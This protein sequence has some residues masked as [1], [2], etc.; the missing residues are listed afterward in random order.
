M[1]SFINKFLIVFSIL[2]YGLF[3]TVVYAADTAS[4][5]P[6]GKTT[7]LDSNGKPLTGGKVYFK[8]PASDSLKTTWQDGAE[9]V[10]NANPVILDSAGRA[11]I[12][13]FG[14]YRQQV[15]DKNSNLIWDTVTSSAGTGGGGGSTVGD[16]NSVGTVLP[17]SGL[18][19]PTNYVFAYGQEIARVTYPQFFT[20]ITTIQAANCTLGSPTLSGL[21][22]TTQIPI[23]API[24]A[25]CLAAGATV[26]SKTASSVTASVNANVSTNILVTFF[27]WGNGNGTTTFNV[28]DYRGRVLAGRDNMGGTAASRL[29]TTYFANASAIGATGGL[30]SSTTTIAQ[31]NLPSYTLP[32]TLGWAQDSS[33]INNMTTGGQYGAGG[34]ATPYVTGSSLAGAVTI[35]G[36]VTGS[37][38]SGGSGTAITNSIVQPTITIN[39]I[40]KVTPDA[41]A[42][43]ATLATPSPLTKTDDTNVTLTLG[44]TPATS[45]L[46]PV[47]LTLGWNGTLSP[48]RGGTGADLSATGGTSQVVKQTSVGGAFTVGQLANTDISGLGTFATQN[49]ATPPAIGGGT[50]AAGAFTTLSAT[51]NLTTNVTGTQCLHVAGT[52]VISG[53]GADCGNSQWVTSGSDIYYNAGKV[54]IGTATPGYLLDVGSGSG[55]QVMRINGGSSGASAGP[56]LTFGYGGVNLAAI[57]GY[58]AILGGAYNTALVFYTGGQDFIFSGGNVGIGNIS[59][60]AKL[61]I[62]GTM[63]LESFSA[64]SLSVNASHNVSSSSPVVVVCANAAGDAAKI[65]T[66]ITTGLNVR[67]TG[68]C[69]GDA[70]ISMTTP[71]QEV[72]CDSQNANP[73]TVSTILTT[74]LFVYTGGEPGPMIRDCYIKAVQPDTSTRASLTAYTPAFYMVSSPRFRLDHVRCEQFIT[75]V[76]MTGN[77]GGAVIDDFLCAAYTACAKIDGSL[78]TVRINNLHCWPLSMTAAQTILFSDPS[79][80]CL[81]VARVDGLFITNFVSLEGTS[82]DVYNSGSG[83]PSVYITNGGFDT[84]N[85]IKMSAGTVQVSNSYFSIANNSQSP[86]VQTGGVLLMSNTQIF[87]AGVSGANPAVNIFNTGTIFQWTNGYID[88][89][90]GNDMIEVQASS[91]APQITL[92]DIRVKKNSDVAYTNP[93]FLIAAGRATMSGNYISD[94]GAGAGTFIQV[95]A[96]DYHNVTSNTAPGWAEVNAVIG[97]AIF[98]NNNPAFTH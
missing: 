91:G 49:Y 43:V 98:A 22:D 53:T 93:V 4:I 40:V 71:G 41:N 77:S 88:A 7:F 57:G 23:N 69:V 5:L 65:Q 25:S 92:T 17:W 46:I 72:V 81:N 83:L 51:G 74:G 1:K 61:D 33:S 16:G 55:N 73:I 89:S 44:G 13:G 8:I 15:Y 58:S 10:P 29:T 45:L 85:G 84:Y 30:E 34:A 64:G 28:P 75:C 56:A 21:T 36:H 78:D 60:T 39:Y 68:A 50:P 95:D 82:L 12:W 76:D 54:G 42:S 94:K 14:S 11:I 79:S 38:T 80:E 3:T 31:A 2:S 96:D 62:T 26:V 63:N 90:G 37:V 48:T 47:S 19:A 87:N 86:I 32:N 59:P 18:I 52:G 9:T 6:N 67:I 70:A 66:A 20:A 97:S 27:P 24:E 35:T